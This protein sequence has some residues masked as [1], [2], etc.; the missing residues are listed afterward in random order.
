MFTQSLLLI[1]SELTHIVLDCCIA[2]NIYDR[3]KRDKL[4][5]LL[6]LKM[7]YVK[8]HDWP[9]IFPTTDPRDEQ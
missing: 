6:G 2:L 1:L 5:K 3:L 9:G 7:K 8:I 4:V